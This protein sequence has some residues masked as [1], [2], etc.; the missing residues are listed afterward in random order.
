[1]AI[2]STTYEGWVYQHPGSTGIAVRG[3]ASSSGSYITRLSASNKGTTYYA[4]DRT[5]SGTE[6]D[7]Y[8]IKYYY[9]GGT[10]GSTGWSAVYSAGFT[11]FTRGT[12]K[13][14]YSG[15]AYAYYYYPNAG[16]TTYIK[17]STKSRTTPAFTLASS[18][19][20]L[21]IDGTKSNIV[22]TINYNNGTTNGSQTGQTWT[23]TPYTFSG[24]DE[25][26]SAT[27]PSSLTAGTSDYSAGASRSTKSDYYYYADYTKGTATTQYSNNTVSSLTTP[28]KSNDTSTSYTVSFSD[29]HNTHNDQT[30]TITKTYTFSKWTNASGGTV[31]F[32]YT[33][34][35]NTTITANYSE[36]G[37][38]VASIT[39]PTPTADTYTFGGWSDGTTVYA[40][41]ASYTPS[42]DITLTAL[43]TLNQFTVTLAAKTGVDSVSG[44]GA[45]T[46]GDSVTISATLKTGYRWTGWFNSGTTTMVS[47][48]Q[49]YTFT[50]PAE[51]LSYDAFGHKNTYKVAYN[52]NGGSGTMSTSTFY[53]DTDETLTLNSFTRLGYAFQGWATSIANAEAGTVTYSDGATVKNLTAVQDETITLYAVWKPTT[54]MYIYAKDSSG[55]LTWMPALKYVYST[56]TTASTYIYDDYTGIDY[57]GSITYEVGQTWE[58]W[59]DSKYNTPGL[60]CSGGYVYGPSGTSLWSFGT[61]EQVLSTDTINSNSYEFV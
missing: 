54:K 2:T 1:M 30:A 59:C 56:V 23:R 12:D 19:G 45:K 11:Y 24:W 37:S 47:S 3:S 6:T 53:Y 42:S 10:S 35:S 34:T 43:W 38:S 51:N 49:N 36:S 32:P 57:E 39:L 52:A 26:S 44:G 58:Q 48:D 18:P 40:G 60:Y 25:K 21:T 8:W 4:I 7:P 17:Q 13:T 9:N 28:S 29:A 27:A 22:L 14:V 15:T 61:T 31:S 46:V 50:M 20:G 41:G 16:T 55:N 5:G 33:F